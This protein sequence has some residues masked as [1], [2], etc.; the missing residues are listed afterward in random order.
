MTPII[1]S[2]VTDVCLVAGALR[3]RGDFMREGIR[4][5][6][7]HR[8][9][10]AHPGDRLCVPVANFQAQMK[11]LYDQGYRTITLEDLA[12][13]VK[14]GGMLGDKPVVLT[15]DDG[16]ADNF[17]WAAPTLIRHGFRA[18]FFIPTGLLDASR[19][20]PDHAMTWEQLRI[21]HI[22]GHAIGA[23]SV[24][25]RNLTLLTPAELE[26]EVRDSKRVIEQRLGLE[27]NYFC[28]PAGHCNA[29]VRQAVERAGYRAACT[30][31]PGANVRDTDPLRLRRTEIG[32][33]DTLHD[34]DKKLAG[35]FDAWHRAAQAWARVSGRG[36]RHPSNAADGA[37]CASPT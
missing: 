36:R 20:A 30:V 26:R 7:Y 1:R 10:N 15:F 29:A 27:V 13:W 16:Y 3:G 28:Y 5:L 37:A 2:L 17:E 18:T 33:A 8:V 25:H 34:V 4:V 9:T 6:M 32:G 19:P 21:L 22:E 11:R 24:T 12:R 23:H 14:G 35:A 31:E